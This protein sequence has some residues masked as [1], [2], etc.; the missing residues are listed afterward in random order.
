M[1][2]NET[3]LDDIYFAGIR[4]IIQTPSTPVRYRANFFNYDEIIKPRIAYHRYFDRKVQGT[5]V[6][7]NLST[8][9][10]ENDAYFDLENVSGLEAIIANDIY[11]NISNSIEYGNVTD[12]MGKEFIDFQK[13]SYQGSDYEIWVEKM[14]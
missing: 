13:E 12:P 1:V 5:Y 2:R 9:G 3:T 4:I 11:Q 10:I 8:A 7:K 14:V 6:L